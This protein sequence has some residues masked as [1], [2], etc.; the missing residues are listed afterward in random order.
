[1]KFRATVDKPL[2][3]LGYRILSSSEAVVKSFFMGVQNEPV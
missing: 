3:T 2:G 1:M